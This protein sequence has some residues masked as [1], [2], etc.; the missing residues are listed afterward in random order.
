VEDKSGKKNRPTDKTKVE[1]VEEPT[2]EEIK[3]K[4]D[5]PPSRKKDRE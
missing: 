3:K 2:D 1:T 5:V 4:R